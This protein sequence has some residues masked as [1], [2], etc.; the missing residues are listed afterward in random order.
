M[1]TLHNMSVPTAM[2]GMKSWRNI[3]PSTLGAAA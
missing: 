3:P 1:K 2:P